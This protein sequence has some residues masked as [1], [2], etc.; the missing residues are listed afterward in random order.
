MVPVHL[1]AWGV[2]SFA[3]TITCLVEV[4]GWADRTVAEKQNITMLY[5]P[6][7]AVGMCHPSTGVKLIIGLT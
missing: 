1:L 5:G 7:A 2:Q 6:Y 3:T 4:W